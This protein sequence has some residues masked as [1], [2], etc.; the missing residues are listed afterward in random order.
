MHVLQSCVGVWHRVC[1]YLLSVVAG[2]AGAL[3]CVSMP[4]HAFCGC[5]PA[6]F[7]CARACLLAC[8]SSQ[9][10]FSVGP[11][12]QHC[13]SLGV[14]LLLVSSEA[15]FTRHAFW[16]GLSPVCVSDAWHASPLSGVLCTFACPVWQLPASF[17]RSCVCL[18]A[19]ACF[20]F[21]LATPMCFCV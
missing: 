5:L 9:Y 17:Q 2:G 3:C 13:T 11:V 20:A 12:N 8:L 15:P 7:V 16:V 19:F 1:S 4:E 14:V 6:C 18:H 21:V 10:T